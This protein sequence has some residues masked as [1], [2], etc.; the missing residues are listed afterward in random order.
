MDFMEIDPTTLTSMISIQ[1]DHDK[2]MKSAN[3]SVDSN[4]AFA[5]GST[6]YLKHWGSVQPINLWGDG[7]VASATF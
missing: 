5:D 7:H 2:H 4:F 1:L 3:G 6:R